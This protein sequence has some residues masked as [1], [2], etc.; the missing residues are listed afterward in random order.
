[1]VNL[2]SKREAFVKGLVNNAGWNKKQAED[3]FEKFSPYYEIK[4][5]VF[6]VK[7]EAKRMAAL[8]PKIKI[9]TLFYKLDDGKLYLL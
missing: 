7:S 9:T 6:F 2:A 8:Y 5:E 4:D 3:Y 1:M